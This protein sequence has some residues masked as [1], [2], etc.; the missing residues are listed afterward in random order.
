M[1]GGSP[2]GAQSTTQQAKG[3]AGSG[4]TGGTKY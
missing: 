3:R 4:N 2:S 1:N